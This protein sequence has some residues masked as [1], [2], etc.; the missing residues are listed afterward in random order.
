[1][2]ILGPRSVRGHSSHV[3]S[4]GSEGNIDHMSAFLVSA[5]VVFPDISSAKV[6]E[7]AKP[8][9]KRK[10]EAPPAKTEV[11]LRPGP[12]PAV[13]AGRAKGRARSHGSMT[14]TFPGQ[15]VRLLVQVWGRNFRVPEAG[16]ERACVQ[17]GRGA[18]GGWR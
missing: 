10:G 8:Q 15:A 17:S 4:R 14:P 11:G 16:R 7:V 9:I 18:E 2:S 13:I 12:G 3:E 6:C 1:M 5:C